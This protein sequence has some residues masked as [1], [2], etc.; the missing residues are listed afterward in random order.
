MMTEPTPLPP[1]AAEIDR[2]RSRV[3]ELEAE[4]ARLTKSACQYIA[5][6]QPWCTTHHSPWS[7]SESTQCD[8]CDRHPPET[9]MT[10]ARAEAHG[11]RAERERI[12]AELRSYQEDLDE[13][14]TEAF[15]PAWDAAMTENE[16]RRGAGKAGVA[17][18][19]FLPQLRAALADWLERQPFA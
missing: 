2:Q 4:V 12:V 6:S 8:W 10:D 17:T 18:S 13:D 9:H 14:L 7:N 5:G 19:Q 11:R 16:R 1:L 15:W 3:A